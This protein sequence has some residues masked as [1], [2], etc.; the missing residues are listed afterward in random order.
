MLDADDLR[1][2]IEATP[3]R[4]RALVALS[5]MTGL[6]QSEALG[7]R[8]RDVDLGDE[9]TIRVRHQLDRRGDLVEP[10]TKAARRDVPL[11]PELARLLHEHKAGS[12]FASDD[13]FVFASDVGT[14]LGHRN[15]SRR[16]LDPATK[17]AGLPHLRWHDLRHLA[18]SALIEAGTSDHD[19]SRVLGH[20]DAVVTK[21][22]Y[23]HEFARAERVERTRERMT[24]AYAGVLA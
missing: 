21:T 10:K 12:S 24:T 20:G 7:L 13:D 3:D 18:A 15:L 2:L 8:W 22:T 1:R 5:L 4:Y 16:A 23:A 19:L 17:A 11:T 14:P 9:P 6:R